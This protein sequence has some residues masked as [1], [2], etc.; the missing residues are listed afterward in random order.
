MLQE[1]AEAVRERRVSPVELVEEALR[2]IERHN[3]TINAVTALRAEEALADARAMADAGGGALEGPLAGIPMLVKD[4]ARTK[5]MRTTFGH[6]MFADAP[7]DD[8]D[9]VVVG[10]LRAAGAIV[11]GRSNT[12]AFGH[13]AFTSNSL[14]GATRNPW[15]PERTPGGSSGGSS[16]AL[17]AALTPLATTSDGGGSTRAPA[18]LCGLVGYK[19]TNGAYGRNFTPRWISFST[20]GTS[21]RSVADVSYE[22]AIAIGGVDGDILS[23]P[24]GTADLTPRMP[25]RIIAV[26]TFRQGIDP[27]IAAAFDARVSLMEREL[28][29]PV[30]RMSLPWVDELIGKWLVISCTELAQSLAHVRDQWDSFEQ[31]L[32]G[33]LNLGARMTAFDYVAAQRDR[34]TAAARFDELLAGDAVLVVPTQNAQSWGPEGPLPSD[35]GGVKA[36][37]IAL[38]TTDGNYTGHPGISVPLGHDDAGVPFGMQIVAPRF[39]DGLAFGLAAAI[40]RIA[41]WPTVATGYEPWPVP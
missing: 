17:A 34:F 19:P 41:P 25:R 9:D 22:A 2:R 33:L 4:M 38:N 40:E 37:G 6:P 15:N 29:L 1:L 8:A 26:P 10:R 5:G 31:S 16:A 39:A 28:G 21:G 13:T 3:P 7:I 24:R 35:A 18:S 11:I 14:H 30:E 23:F 20:L 27:V 12:P 36:M 32:S